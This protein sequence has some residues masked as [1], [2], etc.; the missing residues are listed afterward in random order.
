MTPLQFVSGV[1]HVYW[2][3][4]FNWDAY[5]YSSADYDDH[6]HGGHGHSPPKLQSENDNLQIMR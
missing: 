4:Q 3:R 6:Y 1:P 5:N 2:K